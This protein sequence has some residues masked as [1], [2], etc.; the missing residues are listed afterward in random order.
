MQVERI[1]KSKFNRKGDQGATGSPPAYVL[2]VMGSGG[3]SAVPSQK[4]TIGTLLRP[5]AE[6]FCHL[7]SLCDTGKIP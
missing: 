4:L 5:G 3:S 6:V 2:G 1:G 7:S